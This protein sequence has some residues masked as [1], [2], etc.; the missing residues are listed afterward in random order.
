MSGM[1]AIIPEMKYRDSLLHIVFAG[2]LNQISF[3][4]DRVY[5]MRVKIG[6]TFF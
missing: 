4:S 3:S 2:L 1:L 6:K 5:G